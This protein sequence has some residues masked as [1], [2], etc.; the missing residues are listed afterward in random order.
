MYGAM[1]K[2]NVPVCFMHMRGDSKTMVL[3]EN[4]E[5]PEDDVVIGVREELAVRVHNALQAGVRRWHILIDPGLGFAKHPHQSIQLLR[6]LSQVVARGQDLEGFP[7]LVGPSR[8][9]FIGAVINKTEADRVFGTAAAC[10]ALIAEGV[11][12]LRVHDVSEMSDVVKISD[13][14]WRVYKK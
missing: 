9:G 10:S 7:T 8:K 3:A 6:S 11:D 1:A 5:Y 4:K 12:V 13:A 2:A 14:V